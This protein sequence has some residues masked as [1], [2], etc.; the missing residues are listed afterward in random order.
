MSKE[1][2]I[3]KRH[4]WIW[5][6]PEVKKVIKKYSLQVWINRSLKYLE[7]KGKIG[8]MPRLAEF[9]KNHGLWIYWLEPDINKGLYKKDIELLDRW[10]VVKNIIMTEAK[11]F[12]IEKNIDKSG[13]ASRLLEEEH[14]WDKAGNLMAG[15]L[16]LQ[17]VDWKTLLLEDEEEEQLV[18]DDP[19]IID[20]VPIEASDVI[21]DVEPEEEEEQTLEEITSS[22]TN[23]LEDE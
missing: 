2:E 22:L 19:N 8:R 21:I 12:I 20:V 10:F 16:T 14:D 18:L 6:A 23:F 1:T 9:Y 3:A 5:R 15:G 4:K 7:N 11:Y 13:F 17:I